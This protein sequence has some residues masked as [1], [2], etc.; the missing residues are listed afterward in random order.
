M[1]M[2][3]NQINEYIKKGKCPE[4]CFCPIHTTGYDKDERYKK[5]LKCWLDKLAENKIE[6]V[7]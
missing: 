4:C 3:K 5:C 1:T 2:S 7:D 6:V